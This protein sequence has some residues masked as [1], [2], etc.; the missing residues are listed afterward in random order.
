MALPDWVVSCGPGRVVNVFAPSYFHLLAT[1]GPVHARKERECTAIAV[2][3]EKQAHPTSNFLPPPYSPACFLSNA[4]PCQ[5]A[6]KPPGSG[7][8][9]TTPGLLQR[10]HRS[11]RDDSSLNLSIRSL[12]CRP[13]PDSALSSAKSRGDGFDQRRICRRR[14]GLQQLLFEPEMLK[15]VQ[16]NASTIDWKWTIGRN[17]KNYN[18]ELKK[19]IPER[20]YF[21]SRAQRSNNWTVIVDMDQSGSM[22]DSMVYGAVCGT[23]F[24]SLPALETHVV[25]FDTEGVDLTEQCSADRKALAKKSPPVGAPFRDSTTAYFHRRSAKSQ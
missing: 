1:R 21:F 6:A 16:P 11:S 17:L 12:E 23:I 9:E 13:I 14:R 5:L 2:I 18:P 8:G 22:A 10:Q 15:I 7:H 3:H 24:V 25:A 20:V 19:I 4:Q